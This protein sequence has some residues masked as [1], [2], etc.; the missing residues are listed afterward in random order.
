MP[1]FAR[2]AALFLMLIVAAPLASAQQGETQQARIERLIQGLGADDPEVRDSSQKELES[3]GAPALS[4]LEQATE[5]DDPEVALRARES[6]DVIGAGGNRTQP[7]RDETRRPPQVPQPGQPMPM[8]DMNELMRESMKQLQDQL[9]PEFRELF[10]EMFPG[11]EQQDPNAQRD[12]ERNGSARPRVRVWS[13]NNQQPG[14]QGSRSRAGLE[15]ELGI[16]GGR[17]SA[18]LRAQLEIK[19]NEGLVISKVYPGGWADA[20]GLRLY[21]VIVAIDGRSVRSARDLAPLREK[22]CDVQLYRKAKLE[23]VTLSAVEIERETRPA[24]TPAPSPKDESKKD[25][26]RSF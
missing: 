23:T 25:G 20:H 14:Q 26:E 12:E 5:S 8:P 19:G 22:A 9:P 18:A 21:D 10:G 6:I 2:V 17:A 13:W 16:R 11:E 4:A 15:G 1:T 3:I 24:P 7:R